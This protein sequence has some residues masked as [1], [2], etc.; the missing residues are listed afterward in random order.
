MLLGTN[1]HNYFPP[2]FAYN[3]LHTH[4]LLHSFPG[5]AYTFSFWGKAAGQQVTAA[6]LFLRGEGAMK[7]G[8]TADIKCP[9]FLSYARYSITCE[10]FVPGTATLTRFA[11]A[12]QRAAYMGEHCARMPRDTGCEYCRWMLEEK[13]RE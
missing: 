8:E 4:S 12:E 3:S 6:F 11:S 13:H 9:F 2:L 10:G 7:Y 1:G 5:G